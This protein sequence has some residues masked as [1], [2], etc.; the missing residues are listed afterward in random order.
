MRVYTHTHPIIVS[1]VCLLCRLW[2][3]ALAVFNIY[4][5]QRAGRVDG[6]MGG[7]W[8][9]GEGGYGAVG[10]AMGGVDHLVFSRLKPTFPSR[11]AGGE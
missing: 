6:W 2:V 1:S 7:G 8:G 5:A 10:A 3:H 4:I 11:R 9:W